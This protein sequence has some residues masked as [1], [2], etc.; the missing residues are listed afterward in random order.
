MVHRGIAPSGMPASSGPRGRVGL[1]ARLRPLVRAVSWHRRKLAVLCAVAAVL[2]GLT[3]L[4]PPRP[5][6]VP[7]V[8]ARTDLLGGT[9]VQT[10]DLRVDQLPVEAL[11]AGA[12]AEPG[13]AVGRTLAG[14]MPAGQIVAAAD[15]VGGRRPQAS[16]LVVSPLRLADGDVAALLSDGDLVDVVGADEQS[17]K[18][19]VVAARVRVVAVPA[20]ARD[21][22]SSAAGGLVLVEVDRATATTLAQ[23]SV[24]SQLGVV[25]R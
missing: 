13:A 23:A 10:A 8:R 14:R 1:R 17:G 4:A 18:A 6:T 7:V 5:A 21:P 3:A 22:S 19:R 2:T 25:W 11:P 15:L 20:A 16:G 12:L 9:V 24:T